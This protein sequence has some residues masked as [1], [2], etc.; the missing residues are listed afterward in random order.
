VAAWAP[1]IAEV[2][3]RRGHPLRDA[4]ARLTFLLPA[5][6]RL[7]LDLKAHRT[8]GGR[9]TPL[10]TAAADIL[11]QGS[12]RHAN[13]PGSSPQENARTAQKQGK[14]TQRNECTRG[15]LVVGKGDQSVRASEKEGS[16]P[17][18]PEALKHKTHQCVPGLY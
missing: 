18:R 7:V 10:S 13:H 9:W 17:H 3:V 6:V 12:K 5:L 4:Q 15:G 16:T 2:P 8:G 14:P 11:T 1:A